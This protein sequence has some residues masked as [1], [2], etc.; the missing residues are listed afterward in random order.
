MCK[1]YGQLL[2]LDPGLQTLAGWAVGTHGMPGYLPIKHFFNA[3]RLQGRTTILG[4]KASIDM[5]TV[6]SVGSLQKGMPVNSV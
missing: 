2:C 1:Q 3:H 4:P 5:G 6:A